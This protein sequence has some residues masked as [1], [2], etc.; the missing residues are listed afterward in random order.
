MNNKKFRTDGEKISL[1]VENAIK[2]L[3][4]FMSQLKKEQKNG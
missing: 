1:I 4:K 3:N 2:D